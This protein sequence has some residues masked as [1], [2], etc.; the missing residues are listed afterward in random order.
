M[1]YRIRWSHLATARLEALTDFIA[2]KS[3]IA[4]VE[5]VDRL[6]GGVSILEDHPEAG[7]VWPRSNDGSIRRL[8]VG[9]YLVYYEVFVE[10]EVVKIHTVKHGRERP[11]EP[12]ELE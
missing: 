10:G 11:L 1:S 5:M 8:V 9:A 4:A 7:M 3:T 12:G 2:E 6:M